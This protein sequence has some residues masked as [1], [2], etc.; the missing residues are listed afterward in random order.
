MG[1]RDAV[2]FTLEYAAEARRLG[3]EVTFEPGWEKRG[4]GLAADY[5][6]AEVH[7][8][9]FG[10]SAAKTFPGK[11]TLL[12]GRPDLGGP[13]TNVG[14]PWCPPERPRLHIFAAHPSNNAGASSTRSKNL[15]P[16]PVSSLFNKHVWA[17]EIDYGGDVPMAPGQ[18]V[19]AL[20]HA[21]A[22]T[23]VLRR[24]TEYVRAHFET[25]ITGK[26][27][28]GYAP[29]KSIDMGA[30]RRDAA[31]Y[32]PTTTEDIDM[33]IG[34]DILK[35]LQGYGRRIEIIQENLLPGY[36]GRIEHTEELAQ[37]IAGKLV[38]YG[39]RIENT[40]AQT[41][42][43][44]A[45]MGALAG[46]VQAATASGGGLTEAQARAAAEEGAEAALAKLG[47]TLAGVD[48]PAR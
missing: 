46:M 30:F 2:Q 41:S 3:A 20:I 40:E 17:L 38:G 33:A 23:N 31:T 47:A 34:D 13:L 21:R 27:D 42:A 29:F 9:G 10:S 24:S 12:A 25:S 26:W 36:G 22:T 4:N 45:Q 16:M 1:R 43:L 7:H 28:P 19:A 44:V 48:S 8:T 14:G 11:S 5:E 6:G 37:D 39:N 18:R 32:I 35:A 15:G